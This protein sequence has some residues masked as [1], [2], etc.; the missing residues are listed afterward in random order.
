MAAVGTLA[1]ALGLAGCG[2]KSGLDP[3]PAASAS[4]VDQG[5][6]A[7]A[8][9]I[10]PDGKPVVPAPAPAVRRRQTPVDWLIQ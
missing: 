5:G 4:A 2:R 3:P 10:G 1:A 6:A 9:A 7:T 8:A